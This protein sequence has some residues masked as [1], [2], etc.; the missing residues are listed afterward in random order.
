MLYFLFKGLRR[1]SILIPVA[2][3]TLYLFIRPDYYGLLLW[4]PPFSIG[5][6]LSFFKV[7]VENAFYPRVVALVSLCLL[8]L[9]AFLLSY[10]KVDFEEKWYFAHRFLSPVMLW[11]SLDLFRPLFERERIGEVF[12]TS[13]FIFF[14]HIFFVYSLK[15]PPDHGNLPGFELPLPRP[16]LPRL[17]PFRLVY[18]DPRLPLE[19]FCQTRLSGIVG[20]TK[21]PYKP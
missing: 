21:R 9:L 10:F 14:S 7:K 3:L 8:L 1:F 12:K 17:A 16:V 2:L 13:P 6:N 4:I 20:K 18:R 19:A 5:A 15:L 11:L